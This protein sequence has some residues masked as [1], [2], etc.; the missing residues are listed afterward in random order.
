MT[1]IFVYLKYSN[2]IILSLEARISTTKLVKADFALAVFLL[3]TYLLML[4]RGLYFTV[5]KGWFGLK[6]RIEAS[7]IDY[8][9]EHRSLL[10]NFQQE[11]DLILFIG[12]FM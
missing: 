3:V 10:R 4:F 9:K 5:N 2:N 8:V 11:G 6:T 12:K 7:R 1:C